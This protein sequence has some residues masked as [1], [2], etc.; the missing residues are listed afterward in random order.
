MKPEI[1]LWNPENGT[2]EASEIPALGTAST[3]RDTE[4]LE[5]VIIPNLKAIGIYVQVLSEASF[6]L[7]VSGSNDGVT[8][9][10]QIF[11]P[12][13]SV[14]VGSNHARR[15]FSPRITTNY[16]KILVESSVGSDIIL[17]VAPSYGVRPI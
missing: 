4:T 13:S 15:F 7:T 8:Y 12:L 2:Y 10:S 5:Q 9:Y 17:Q 6:T 1:Y 16:L 14:A 3:Y 11:T